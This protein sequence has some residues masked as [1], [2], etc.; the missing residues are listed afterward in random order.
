M[1]TIKRIL[2]TIFVLIIVS[3]LGTGMYGYTLYEDKL[4]TQPLADKVSDIENS[5]NFVSIEDVPKDYINAIREA[6]R[7]C[8]FMPK[9]N[10]IL[11]LID[12]KTNTRDFSKYYANNAWCEGF[13][14]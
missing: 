6:Y 7:S 10:E 2:I 11:Q 8:K 1:K 14:E 12:T 5:P 4:K 9:L 3:A 13:K